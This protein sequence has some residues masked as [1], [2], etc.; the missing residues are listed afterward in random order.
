MID[1]E[2]FERIARRHGGYAS[3][4]VW[5]TP[6]RGPKSNVGDLTMFNV[7][8]NPTTLQLLKNDIVMVGLNIS[9]SFAERFRNFHDPS[10]NANDFKIRHAFTQTPYY[11][12]Y[13]TDIIKDVEMVSSTDLLEHLRAVPSILA[14]SI[15]VFREE[16]K[17]LGSRK[18][19]ILAFG[20]AAFRLVAA[21]IPRQEYSSLVRLTHYSHRMGK[22]QY[23]DTVLAQIAGD[24]PSREAVELDRA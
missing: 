2:Q 10:P 1:I 17:D 14:T 5:A 6:T 15:E 19:T 18:P 7:A 20:S 23:R 21:N 16:L 12:A 24:V 22:E 8:E 13:M 3:W 4:A 11:G 9:R